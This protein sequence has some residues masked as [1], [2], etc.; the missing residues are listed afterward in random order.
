MLSASSG[1]RPVPKLYRC[2]PC[3]VDGAGKFADL[4]PKRR[5]TPLGRT[6]SRPRVT[7]LRGQRA[8]ARYRGQRPRGS[9]GRCNG[10]AF[11][12]R[13]QHEP[14]ESRRSFA[15]C[16]RHEHSPARRVSLGTRWFRHEL[17]SA[18]QRRARH[19]DHEPQWLCRR[20]RQSTVQ[21]LLLAESP[22]RSQR[23]RRAE[24]VYRVERAGGLRDSPEQRRPNESIGRHRDRRVRASP[25]GRK[26]DRGLS[27]GR[28]RGPC[29]R[30]RSCHE[31]NAGQ[32][33]EISFGRQRRSAHRGGRR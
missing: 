20:G 8:H 31:G 29:D 6:H 23:D 21:N 3:T 32:R 7:D 2:S 26:R 28:P 5:I 10:N 18:G 9:A 27:R 13:S 22:A 30:R 11:C 17:V 33:R 4:P 15:D 24:L 25:H 12:G 19:A 1:I 14:A 16:Q